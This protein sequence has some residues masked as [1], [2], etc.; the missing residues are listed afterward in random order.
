MRAVQMLL[1]GISERRLLDS[2][3]FSIRT[4]GFG[5][6]EAGFG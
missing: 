6:F 1:A 2:I 3:G 5:V 4:C